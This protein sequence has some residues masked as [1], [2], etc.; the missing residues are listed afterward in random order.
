M[1]LRSGRDSRSIFRIHAH[2]LLF[3]VKPS[4]YKGIRRFYTQV[5]ICT[6]MHENAWKWP[7][8]GKMLGKKLGVFVVKIRVSY[9]WLGICWENSLNW[10]KKGSKMATL[11]YRVKGSSKTENSIYVRLSLGRNWLLETKT[12][13]IVTP[14]N[15]NPEQ[16][17]PRQRTPELKILH[18]KLKKL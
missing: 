6:K 1:G 18:H 3:T 4:K 13:F 12:G 10:P 14:S 17:L 16:G 11:K 9:R 15:W 8:V 2:A 7:N 5:W